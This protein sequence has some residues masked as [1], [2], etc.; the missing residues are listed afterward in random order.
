[1]TEGYVDAS[2]DRVVL[3]SGQEYITHVTPEPAT[4]LLLG[5]G[6]VVLL[7]AAGA[8]RKPSA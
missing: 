7:M 8:F 4:L 5:T 2:H 6:L 3:G 1:M